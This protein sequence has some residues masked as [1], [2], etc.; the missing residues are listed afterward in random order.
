MKDCLG[1]VKCISHKMGSEGEVGEGGG[2]ES[3]KERERER[4]HVH[5]QGEEMLAQAVLCRSLE[6]VIFA[7]DGTALG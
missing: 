4:R 7:A 5:F 3:V 2:R 1:G 6:D